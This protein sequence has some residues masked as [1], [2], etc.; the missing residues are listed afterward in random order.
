[1]ILQTC[2]CVPAG[3]PGLGLVPAEADR[4]GAEPHDAGRH[5]HTGGPAPETAPPSGGGE[6]QVPQPGGAA[7][8]AAAVSTEQE[9]NAAR[10]KNQELS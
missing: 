6:T 4:V 8:P 3:E 9:M 2:L 7:H 1:M 5:A 10:A